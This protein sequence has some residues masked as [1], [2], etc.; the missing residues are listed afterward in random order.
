VSGQEA[1]TSTLESADRLPREVAS[2]LRDLLLTL[3]DNKRLLGMRYS[4]CMLGSPSLET[5]IAASSMAQDEWGHGRL[6]YALLSDFGDEPKQL[7]HERQSDAYHSMELLDLPF[8]SWIRMISAAF[9][10]DP[11]LSVQYQ[12]LAGSRYT[13]VRNRVQK[14]LDEEVLHFQYAAGWVGHLARS[15]MADELREDLA[16]ILPRVLRW[17]GPHD[18]P[19]AAL[20]LEHGLCAGEPDAM[21]AELLER[22][23]GPL[24]QAG[25][26]APLGLSRDAAGWS[27]SSLDFGG[28][29]DRTRRFSAGGPDEETLMRVRGDRNRALL[30][31]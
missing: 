30:M 6:T 12:A 25:L 18:S 3:A 7:E 31:D 15:Q 2:A 4:D 14:L 13:P 24:E 28:W 10:I 16:E 27:H 8:R 9:L 1:V 17:F 22:V 21:R 23:A 29:N 5:G 19:S 26:A 11:A 20:L